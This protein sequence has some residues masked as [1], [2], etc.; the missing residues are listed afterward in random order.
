[1]YSVLVLLARF[2]GT[3][4]ELGLQ[5][6]AASSSTLRG[7]C[8][9]TMSPN[10]C[11]KA[12]LSVMPAAGRAVSLTKSY[13]TLA[14][15]RPPAVMRSVIALLF[16]ASF[17]EAVIRLFTAT[18]PVRSPLGGTGSYPASRADSRIGGGR[19]AAAGSGH[20]GTL[21]VRGR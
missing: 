17:D 1:M 3:T 5:P 10:P 7:V 11:Q 14:T 15:C 12:S 2:C 6:R 4:I 20:A 8:F 9:S 18:L 19:G 13:R 21:A 16:N